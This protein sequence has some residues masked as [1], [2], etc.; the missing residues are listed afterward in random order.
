MLNHTYILTISFMFCQLCSTVLFAELKE[1]SDS[2][3]SDIHGQAFISI[4]Q[5]TH[6]EQEVSYTRVNLGMDIETQLNAENLTLGE[7]DRIDSKTGELEA[8][9]AD[10]II[11]NFSLGYIYSEQ[12]HRDNPNVPKPEGNYQEGDIVPFKITDP[13]IE[14]AFDESGDDPKPVGFRIGFGEVEGVLSGNIKSLTGNV[15]VALTSTAGNLAKGAGSL[16]DDQCTGA[17]S[18]LDWAY[19]APLVSLIGRP[20]INALPIK[21]GTKANLAYADPNSPFYGEFDEARATSLGVLNGYKADINL[22]LGFFGDINIPLTANNCSIIGIGVC[23]PLDNFQSFHLSAKDED[24]NVTGPSNGMFLSAQSQAL[25][26]STD[27]ANPN[28]LQGYQAVPT[29]SFFNVPTGNIQVDFT[30][31]FG[32]ITR[33]QTEYID[34]GVGLF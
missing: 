7:Y 3:L 6:P 27:L 4:D 24:G 9:S 10:I 31:A 28:N 21:V 26:W 14:F 19:S 1:V 33:P 18:L 12:Y 23:L 32:G 25:E 2:E 11:E 20:L 22:D 29:G 30:A 34:R 16:P 17:C 8:Q 15:D 13:F 5:N